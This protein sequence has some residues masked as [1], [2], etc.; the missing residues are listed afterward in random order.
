MSQSPVAQDQ[1]RQFLRGLPPRPANPPRHAAHRHARRR[2]A[3]QRPVRAALCRAVVR[4]LRAPRSAIRARRSTICW[5][6]TWCSARPC[7]TSRSMP[8][9][10]SAMP[11]AAFLKPVYPGDTLNAVSEVIGLKENSNRKTGIVYVRSRGFNQNGDTVLDYVR[12]VMVRKRDEQA[13]RARRKSAGAAEERGACAARR[14]LPADRCGGLR[15]RAGRQPAPL[16]RLQGGREDRSCRRHHG[17]R[18]RAHDRDAALSEHRAHPFQPVR[19]EQGPLRPPADLWRPRHLAGAR[20]HLQRARQCLPCGG[21]QWRAARGAA[22]RRLH[23]VR[24]VG[25]AGDAPNCPAARMS[26]RCACAPSPP[27]TGRARIFRSRAATTTIRR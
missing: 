17:R 11:T 20:A 3:L 7:R 23:G 9:P 6:F 18:S 15:H 21:D 1:S 4:C 8:S 2:G 25:S 22:V 14:R 26:A 19:R 5:C 16:R 10:I 12:W 27:R 13:R 24:L